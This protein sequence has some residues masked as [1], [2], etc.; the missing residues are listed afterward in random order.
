M[1]HKELKKKLKEL[2]PDDYEIW[3]ER[4]AIMEYDGGMTRKKAEVEAYNCLLKFRK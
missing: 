4:A 2:S 1:D 3:E